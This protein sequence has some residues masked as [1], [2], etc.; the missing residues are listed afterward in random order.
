M[1]SNIYLS[2]VYLGSLQKHLPGLLS[3]ELVLECLTEDPVELRAGEET[4]L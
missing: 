3:V 4:L 1:R 2:K